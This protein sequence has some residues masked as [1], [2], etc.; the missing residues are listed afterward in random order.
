ML[1]CNTTPP[2]S[3]TP[4]LG[5]EEGLMCP[6]TAEPPHRTGVPRASVQRAVEILVG[7]GVSEGVSAAWPRWSFT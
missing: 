7:F 5:H 3:W 6:A 2:A 4:T 1:D